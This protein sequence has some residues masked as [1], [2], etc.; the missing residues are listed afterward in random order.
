M[1]AEVSQDYR[2]TSQS[3]A[4]PKEVNHGIRGQMMRQLAHEHHIDALI[5][6]RWGSGT[7]HCHGEPLFPS[8]TSRSPAQLQSD[9][10]HAETAA[11]SPP[12]RDLRKVAQ[13]SAQVEQGQSG[14]RRD[15]GEGALKTKADSR[16][17]PKPSI[18]PSDV[19]QRFGDHRRIRRGIVQQLR[20]DGAD[21]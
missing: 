3:I 6:E 2:A 16:G 18:R 8:Q 14:P 9:G 5:S 17:S 1:S 7:P 19:A 13:A 21:I 11:G 10:S 20:A 12:H 15:A 4:G